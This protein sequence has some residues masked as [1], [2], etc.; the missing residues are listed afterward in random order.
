MA[1]N[2]LKCSQRFWQVDKFEADMRLIKRMM[3]LFLASS[4][5]F[6]WGFAKLWAP[7]QMQPLGSNSFTH[8]NSGIRGI[9][10]T[11]GVEG[12]DW[13]SQPRRTGTSIIDT[14]AKI[15]GEED[16]TLK[17]YIRCFLTLHWQ[18][19]P[20]NYCLSHP[21]KL[22]SMNPTSSILWFYARRCWIVV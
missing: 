10:T 5:C 16:V 13:P 11:S 20:C 14:W 19:I 6:Y 3:Y 4:F 12:N 18:A 17:P 9:P 2:S 7:K 8:F 15:A 22:I 1:R 21:L